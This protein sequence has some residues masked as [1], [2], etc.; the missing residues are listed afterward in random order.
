TNP[1]VGA[2]GISSKTNAQPNGWERRIYTSTP[3]NKVSEQQQLKQRSSSSV[4]AICGL[5]S[6]LKA[7]Q[8]KLSAAASVKWQAPI[9]DSR[10]KALILLFGIAVIG[11][12]LINLATPY[13]TC[14]KVQHF[15]S[16]VQAQLSA[17]SEWSR[18]HQLGSKLR[19]LLCGFLVSAFFYGMVYMDSASP[20]VNPPAPI[21]ICSK[22]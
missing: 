2:I 15:S 1:S 9:M 20:G 6:S 18:E 5:F 4:D 7:A 17:A 16:S 3:K 19:P 14:D 8:K 10:L 11:Y 22:K 21:S 12:Q 13:I